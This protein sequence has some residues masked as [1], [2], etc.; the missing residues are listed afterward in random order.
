MLRRGNTSTST[1]SL[2]TVEKRLGGKASFELP[3]EDIE[4]VRTHFGGALS[5]DTAPLRLHSN[6][7]CVARAQ[8]AKEAEWLDWKV[9]K[10]LIGRLNELL[11]RNAPQHA[12]SN[13]R[14]SPIFLQRKYPSILDEFEQ[15]INRAHGKRLAVFLDYDGE[16]TG[17]IEE[18]E[19]GM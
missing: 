13:P 9:R 18:F 4:A 8:S 3:E 5:L 19:G 16:D 17:G 12:F 6:V 2:S 1:S 14:P 11:V 10:C 7:T 15:F